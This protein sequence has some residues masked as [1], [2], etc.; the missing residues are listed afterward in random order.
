LNKKHLI[1]IG[2]AVLLLMV[3]LSGCNEI[4]PFS[5]DNR[6]VGIW[7]EQMSGGVMTLFSDGDLIASIPGIAVS[8]E[9][10][11]KDGKFFMTI[12]DEGIITQSSAWDYSF[13][14]DDTT[15]TLTTTDNVSQVFT[16]Q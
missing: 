6:F 10:E 13:S 7:K 1:V 8:G 16:K 14:D 2:T 9:W 15:L 4:N 5:D 3:G 11:I 12:T